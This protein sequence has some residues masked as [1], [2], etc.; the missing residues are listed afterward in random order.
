MVYHTESEIC[1]STLP[2][3]NW[4]FWITRLFLPFKY[5]T[6][7]STHENP[8][9]I[10]VAMPLSNQ[11]PIIMSTTIKPSRVH[12]DVSTD[13]AIFLRYYENKIVLNRHLRM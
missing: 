8:C 5:S 12:P 1:N 3:Y 9:F 4:P 6:Q 11:Q 2:I 7:Q 10:A 13:N